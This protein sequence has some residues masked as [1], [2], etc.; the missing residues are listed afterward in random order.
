MA[1]LV[2]IT[3]RAQRDLVSLYEDIN[4][5][6]SVAALRWYKGM[7]QAILTLEEHPNRCPVTPE[8]K[9]VRHLLYGHKPH[10]YRVIYKVLERKR[11]VEILHIRYGPRRRFKTRDLL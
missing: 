1:Y 7:K 10:V 3:A 4:A 5:K 9:Q 2:N 6:E 11:W 8:S